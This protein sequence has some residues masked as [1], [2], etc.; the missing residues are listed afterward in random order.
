MPELPEVETIKIGLQ[1]KIIGLKISKIQVNSA[2]SFVG[3]PNQVKGQKLLKIWRKAKI[4]GIELSGNVTLL[5][6]L[7]MTGQLIWVGEKSRLI[8]GHP[9]PDMVDKMPNTHTRVIFSFSDGSH[10]YFNDQRRFGWVRIV[11]SGQLTADSSLKNLGPEPLEKEFSREVLKENLLKH[12][13]MPIKVAIMD[14]KVVS[15]VGNIYASEACFNAKLD[16]R[17]KIAELTDKEFK[18]LHGGIIKSL[19]DGIKFG[20]SSRAHF[21]DPEGKK[22][23]F[24]DYAYCYGRDKHPCKICGTKIK[25]IQLGGRGTYFCEHCQI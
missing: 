25:K 24:L 12:K 11:N 6:H 3:D 10:L 15:G 4:L 9:T 14:Q 7:K 19:Q 5:F 8:G 1:K 18:K 20:G 21:V 13:S 23:Y 2:R 16:P 17:K 22:G